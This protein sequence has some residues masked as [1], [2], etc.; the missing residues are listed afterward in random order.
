MAR[1][2]PLDK[3][4]VQRAHTSHGHVLLP[5]GQRT[6]KHHGD[7]PGPT[8]APPA[9]RR[10]NQGMKPNDQRAFVHK[11]IIAGVGGFVS[12]GPGG[13]ISGFVR[14]PS[15]R[16]GS[17]RRGGSPLP[18]RTFGTA[19]GPCAPGTRKVLGRCVGLQMPQGPLTFEQPTGTALVATGSRGAYAPSLDTRAIRL[20]LPGDVL[21][22]DGMCH[23]KADISNKNRAHP[24]GRR[25]L[26]TP[27]EMA[28]LAKAASFG[29]RMENTV[30]RMQKIGVL[31][32]PGR[33]SSSRAPARRQ[34][35]PGPSIINVE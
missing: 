8:Y 11:R 31:K 34:I 2:N 16:G 32:K 24:R 25:P 29:R 3:T 1:R 19:A 27:G 33:R 28:A 13:A 17:R 4:D 18:P 21:G 23:S 14:P 22:K 35:G 30:K 15:K 5:S 12:G 6:G 10:G 7:F 9:P 26:G 20:C